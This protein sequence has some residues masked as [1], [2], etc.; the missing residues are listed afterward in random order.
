MFKKGDR[1][2]ISVMSVY[3]EYGNSG[4]PRNVE[5]VIYQ[6]NCSSSFRYRVRWDNGRTNC[7]NNQDLELVQ[8][9]KPK[10]VSAFIKKWEEEYSSAK[11]A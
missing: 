2:K 9:A 1:V 11:T 6:D 5:G 10:G 7:Y 3:W 8:P 4:N